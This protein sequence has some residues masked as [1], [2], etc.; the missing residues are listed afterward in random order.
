MK[1]DLFQ[2][3]EHCWVF[4]MC[5]HIEC[6]TFTASSFRI[7]NSLTVIPSPPLA[8]FVVMLSKAHL[9]SH[10]RMSSSRWDKAYVFLDKHQ[11]VLCDRRS[12][13]ERKFSFSFFL[14]FILFLDFTILYWFC[15]ISKWICHKYTCVPHPE[16]SSLPIANFQCCY[17][18]QSI[19]EGFM[20]EV[21]FGLG[22]KGQI[23]GT[24]PKKAWNC[25]EGVKLLAV[26]PNE[27]DFAVS[28]FF[29]G[30]SLMLVKEHIFP[31]IISILL[32][33]L[34]WDGR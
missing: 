16:P 2:S 29:L 32:L 15:Q 3:C 10:S 26:I 21:I 24:S 13:E 6:S 8:L 22:L 27:P 12:I 7:W 14:N 34:R 1:T 5:W 17:F 11:P 18:Y 30:K 19:W 23:A 9:T 25:W 4:Q 31:K 28:S 20:K 33:I